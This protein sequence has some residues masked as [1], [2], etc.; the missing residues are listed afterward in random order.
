MDY[1]K[2][3]AV[4]FPDHPGP[5]PSAPGIG[6]VLGGAGNGADVSKIDGLSPAGD[7]E[8]K[9]ATTDK[10][11]T[12]DKPGGK[13]TATALFRETPPE[14]RDVIWDET[15]AN[16][17]VDIAASTSIPADLVANE[18]DVQA[19][20]EA[21]VAAGAGATQARTLFEM[22]ADNARNPTQLSDAE[23]V[24]Q[25]RQEWGDQTDAKIAAARQLVEEATKRWPNLPAYLDQTRLGSN[26]K[27]I[28]ALAEKAARRRT[29]LG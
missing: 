25:L 13:P 19:A 2:A 1:A 5:P 14:L 20:R 29:I 24:E 27:F 23:V 3:A 10:A 22:A 11:P 21:L 16:A 15:P 6:S 17:P 18:S 8:A 28:R 12:E 4:L 7:A 9:A 26:P